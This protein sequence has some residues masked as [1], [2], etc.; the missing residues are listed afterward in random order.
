[1]RRAT[2]CVLL[3]S[4]ALAHAQTSSQPA[5]AGGAA[6]GGGGAAPVAVPARRGNMAA[7]CALL[8]GG[9]G[10]STSTVAATEG[11]GQQGGQ[12]SK[13]GGQGG[14]QGAGG[15]ANPAAA[16]GAAGGAG[17]APVGGAAPVTRPVQTKPLFPKKRTAFPLGGGVG[18]GLSSSTIA[19]RDGPSAAGAGAS[20]ASVSTTGVAGSGRKLLQSTTSAGTVQGGLLKGIL[21]DFDA[22]AASASS[23][24]GGGLVSRFAPGVLRAY[25]NLTPAQRSQLLSNGYQAARLLAGGGGA[26]GGDGVAPVG[27]A[28]PVGG[29]PPS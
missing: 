20:G 9:R 15:V 29:P 25:R 24:S 21:A 8:P 19:V 4:L 3:L 5:A 10:A 26:G 27:G 17:A 11:S 16:A 14:K 23:G 7:L 2:V 13:Q 28:A 6:S 22:G 18:G 1:M 12:G